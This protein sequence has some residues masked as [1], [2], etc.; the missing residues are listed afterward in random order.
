MGGKLLVTTSWLDQVASGMNPMEKESMSASDI[1][2]TESESV[3]L[4]DP[5]PFSMPAV[6]RAFW[7]MSVWVVPVTSSPVNSVSSNISCSCSN[8]IASCRSWTSS[9]CWLLNGF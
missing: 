8:S 3:T 4:G 7:M 2:T 1:V 6:S 9:S 5:S